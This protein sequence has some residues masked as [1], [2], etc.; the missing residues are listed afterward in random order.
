MKNKRIAGKKNRW[1]KKQNIDWS[2]IMSTLSVDESWE[3]FSCTLTDIM[4]SYIP[5]YKP[6]NHHTNRR[7]KNKKNKKNK[8][9]SRCTSTRL[10]IT[11]HFVMQE[12]T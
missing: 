12:I 6:R 5:L 4:E 10:L 11:M 8:L 9:W 7:H 2:L 3:N 1:K